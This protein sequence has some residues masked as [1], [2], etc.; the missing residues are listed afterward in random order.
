MDATQ[1]LDGDQWHLARDGRQYGP[2]RFSI[3]LEAVKRNVLSRDDKV[4]RPGWESWRP[5]HSVAGLF[6]PPILNPL[7]DARAKLDTPRVEAADAIAFNAAG[8]FDKRVAQEILTREGKHDL[9]RRNYFARHWRGELS[10]PVSY[11]LNGLLALV[12]GGALVLAYHA[13]GGG[14]AGYRVAFGMLCFT[15]AATCLST[16]HMVGIW[17]SAS[18]YAINRKSIWARLAKL[19][20]VLGI[21]KSFGDFGHSFLP[22][23]SEHIKIALGDHAMGESR[24]RLLQNGTELEYSGG[25]KIGAAKEFERMLDAAPQVRVLH[26][27]SFGGRV[28]EADLIAAM[29]RKRNLT[30][31]V[32]EQ[33]QSA[34]THVFLAGRE[35]WLGEHGII[36][37]HQPSLPGIDKETAAGIVE[38]ERRYLASMGLPNDFISKALATP[39][40]KMWNPTKSEL[41]AARVISGISDGSRFAVSGAV[42]S[43]PAAELERT[44][45]TNASK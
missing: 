8:D 6:A 43:V 30:T 31:Y 16:W 44:I 2:Y 3:L 28:V 13:F 21:I 38:K 7:V 36:G 39:R 10:L 23:F 25:I 24:F 26:L 32:P 1:E 27:N 5:A 15:V 42:A 22:I 11:W 20:V 4:W 18:R 41:L 29:V 34:C 35:R 45:L 12:A 37:F 14:E 9:V 17:R 33:C 19:T 40:N